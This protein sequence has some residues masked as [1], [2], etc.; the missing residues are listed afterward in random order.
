[1]HCLTRLFY[2]YHFFASQWFRIYKQRRWQG[3]S[4][5]HL[6]VRVKDLSPSYPST[7]N[8][9]DNSNYHKNT[10][11]S[12]FYIKPQL[13]IKS[14]PYGDNCLISLFYIKTQ[15][16]ALFRFIARYCLISLFYIK[17]QLASATPTPTWHCLISL[18]YIKTQQKH[19][20]R[21]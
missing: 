9:N 1:M 4:I 8:H 17:P 13:I 10:A 7:S 18:F 2:Y 6:L 14:W 12:L 20:L 15:R 5:C 19:F 21:R 16:F 3:T 11:L